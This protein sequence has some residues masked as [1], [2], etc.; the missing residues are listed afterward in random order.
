[1]V[2]NRRAR[3]LEEAIADARSAE[4]RTRLVAKFE[5]VLSQLDVARAAVTRP[6]E[7][8]P[9]LLSPEILRRLEVLKHPAAAWQRFRQRTRKEIVR[10]LAETVWIYPDADGYVLV[11]DWH[12]EGRAA[13]KVQTVRRKK[14]YYIPEE[15]RALFS[16]G[17]GGPGTRL[18]DDSDPRHP[19]GEDAALSSLEREVTVHADVDAVIGRK[20][21][22]S[23]TSCRSSGPTSWKP[24]GSRSRTDWW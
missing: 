13:A 6:A 22:R 19:D 17:D 2:L 5:E 9:A 7:P 14:V 21:V 4:A 20:A 12:G 24:C 23:W 8:E 10:A 18:P 16:E 11:M 15:I 1:V 3:M